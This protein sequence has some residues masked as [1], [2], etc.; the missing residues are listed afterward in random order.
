MK[1]RV[2]R[3]AAALRRGGCRGEIGRRSEIGSHTLPKA[4]IFIDRGELEEFMGHFHENVFLVGTAGPSRPHF[5]K[6]GLKSGAVGPPHP[7]IFITL[8]NLRRSW[9][10]LIKILP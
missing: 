9:G 4:S 6:A 8:G 7:T 1:M 2:L 3:V 10:T 5:R